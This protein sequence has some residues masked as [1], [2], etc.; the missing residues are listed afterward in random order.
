MKNDLLADLGF[1]PPEVEYV[2]DDPRGYEYGRYGVE[3]DV[4][5][6]KDTIYTICKYNSDNRFQ[7]SMEIRGDMQ[8]CAWVANTF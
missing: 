6:D 2:R 8:F 3:A 5:K 1:A 4:Q 7:F